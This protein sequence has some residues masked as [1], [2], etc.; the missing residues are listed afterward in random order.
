MTQRLTVALVGEPNSGKSTLFNR[1]L[2]ARKSITSNIPG[3][4][5]DRIYG[6][7]KW[8]N[9]EFL[10]IDTGGFVFEENVF[11]DHINH[12]VE[13]AIDQADVI[14]FVVDYQSFNSQDNAKILKKL[15]QSNKKII[16]C[17]TKVDNHKIKEETDV[18][19]QWGLKTLILTSAL[20]GIGIG[21]LLDQIIAHIPEDKNYEQ[22]HNIKFAFVGKPNVGKSSLVNGILKSKRVIVSSQPGTTRDA[23]DVFLKRNNQNFIIT[24]TA[25]IKK[26][27]QSKALLEKFSL[28]RTIKAITNSD[29]LCLVL[30]ANNKITQQDLNVA[31][32]IEKH[33]KSLLIIVN[34]WDG[35]IC[36]KTTKKKLKQEISAYFKFSN[37]CQ[38]IFTSAITQSNLWKIID[39]VALI[40]KETQK[41]I[42]TTSLNQ[43]VG[44]ITMRNPAPSYKGGKLNI[45]YCFQA[46]TSFPEFVF[47]VNNTKFL[48]FTYQRFLENKLRDYFG[49]NGV[50][51]SLIFRNK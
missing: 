41:K 7:G 8:L 17:I 43:V 13:I 46:K 38:I 4:T 31:G 21:D 26:R 5:R 22:D 40:Y 29:I 19:W 45:L 20:H 12:Q 16:L 51:I 24:D 25:G 27:G 15:R 14:L 18:F 50:Y 30:D 3:T 9:Q 44:E 28:I 1:I 34:K 2:K 32:I 47:F 6:I 36:H 11:N 39:E 48:H 49:F 23:V 35:E 33:K 42:P 10:L 37:N